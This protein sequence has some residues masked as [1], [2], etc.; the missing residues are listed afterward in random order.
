MMKTRMT[1]SSSSKLTHISE[2]ACLSQHG[3]EEEEIPEAS[4][5]EEED[6]GEMGNSEDNGC[7]HSS[8]V[9]F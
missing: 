9:D 1:S 5:T 7:H 6:L 8:S 3:E 4:K 2:G